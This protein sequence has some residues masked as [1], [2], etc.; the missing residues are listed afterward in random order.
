MKV[1]TNA[2]LCADGTIISVQASS[3]HYCSPRTDHP[4]KGYGSVEIR[5]DDKE[6]LGW[7]P[8]AQLMEYIA[9]HGGA[10][11]GQLPPLNFGQHEIEV[12]EEEEE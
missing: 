11:A 2:I 4:D 1:I 8:A 7:V 6:P 9:L 10:I 12:K 5:I 3:G